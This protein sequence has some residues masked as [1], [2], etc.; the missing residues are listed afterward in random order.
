MRKFL[1]SFNTLENFVLNLPKQSCFH[2]LKLRREFFQSSAPALSETNKDTNQSQ[3]ATHSLLH[4]IIGNTDPLILERWKSFKPQLPQP[5]TAWIDQ[6]SMEKASYPSGFVKLHPDVWATYPRLD[7][8]REVITWQHNYRRVNWEFVPNRAE[9]VGGGPK[10]WPQ[11]GLG[12]ARQ[13]SDR[14]P[15]WRGGG[16]TFG[17]RG[18]KSYYRP[19]SQHLKA[20]AMRVVL[21]C[22]YM[23]DDV[24][25]VS[26]F[27][28][29]S[30]QN[31]V[32]FLSNIRKSRNWGYMA[33][34][35]G[36][37]N[38]RQLQEEFRQCVTGPKDIHYMKLSM[39][40]LQALLKFPTV[41]M[42]I[43][44][45]DELEARLLFQIY[46]FSRNSDYPGT[47]DVLKY[48]KEL[49]EQTSA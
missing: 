40:N 25:F 27:S 43:A 30:S 9:L 21:T 33:L 6:L 16:K 29:F 17:P 10:P 49:S 15:Q 13:S 48:V 5:K 1:T 7:L 23:Q 8:V 11:K 2:C 46:R 32:Q 18:P 31:D 19:M 20:H 37:E 22:K 38:E 39:L 14:A 3:V 35:V 44:T 47:S 45:L 24:K 34:F 42:D 4:S 41:V 36:L 26:D 12:K 28:S